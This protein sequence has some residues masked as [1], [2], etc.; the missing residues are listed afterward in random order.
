MD[1][2]NMYLIYEQVLIVRSANS[3]GMYKK[4]SEDSESDDEHE[5]E[6]GAGHWENYFNFD[7]LR[8]QIS[9][10]KGNIRIQITTLDKIYF[11]IINKETLFNDRG[12]EQ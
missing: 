6:D 1:F 12:T 7:N 3:I 4:C 8:G 11:Y 9:F 10:Q 5:N 2:G